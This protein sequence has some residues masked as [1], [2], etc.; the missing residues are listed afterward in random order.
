[1]LEYRSV[2]AY[3]LDAGERLIKH[4]EGMLE[5]P[6]ISEETKQETREFKEY[7]LKVLAENKKKKSESK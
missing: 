3:I 6:K 1:M 4:L 5:D 2:D 7:A